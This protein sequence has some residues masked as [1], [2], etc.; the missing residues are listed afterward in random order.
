MAK[1]IPAR[2][3]QTTKR[4]KKKD[5]TLAVL[6]FSGV[7][8]LFII[9]VI[10]LFSSQKASDKSSKTAK[11]QRNQSQDLPLANKEPV[12]KSPTPAKT[13]KQ[14]FTHDKPERPPPSPTVV[15][16]DNPELAV[17]LV[18]DCRFTPADLKNLPSVFILPEKPIGEHLL[19]GDIC[20]PDG[21]KCDLEFHAA[22]YG[23]P[24][25]PQLLQA[26][27]NELKWDFSAGN[28][29]KP[30]ANINLTENG[31]TFEWLPD[32]NPDMK[33]LLHNCKITLRSGRHQK[34]IQLRSVAT[35]PNIRLFSQDAESDYSFN[36]PH[37]PHDIHW[38][39]EPT[40]PKADPFNAPTVG[41]PTTEG[42][43]PLEETLTWTPQNRNG[44][45]KARYVWQ[46]T[47]KP[48]RRSQEKRIQVTQKK[49]YKI[50]EANWRPLTTD[51]LKED[52]NKRLEKYDNVLTGIKR[53][54]IKGKPPTGK[55]FNTL[56][57]MISEGSAFAD[58]RG[59]YYAVPDRSMRIE[60]RTPCDSGDTLLAQHPVQDRATEPFPKRP[61][62]ASP[63]N[64]KEPA[65]TRRP[66]PTPPISQEKEDEQWIM[67]PGQNPWKAR[68]QQLE[69]LSPRG[70]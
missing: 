12:A 1:R 64:P 8:F 24:H 6:L 39:L 7:G 13:K 14:P 43:I 9:I 34:S 67:P 32:V 68:Q 22:D 55:Q 18:N 50:G 26:S 46:C 2:S 51:S 54:L 28:T 65:D 21:A 33:T 56:R 36:L 19:A 23:S 4:K 44:T 38:S 63:P 31:I 60:F 11:R 49:E 41:T 42:P 20:F 16:Q 5:H 15:R 59:F 10:L 52:W 35:G 47:S 37:A 27:K 25:R 69:N 53:K 62:A 57:R 30:L 48:G 66:Q 70:N 40:E 29:R 17:E 61:Q 45:V 58:V 3:S